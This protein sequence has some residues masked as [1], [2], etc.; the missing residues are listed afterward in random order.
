[1][2]VPFCMCV[3]V[4]AEIPEEGTGSPGTA[5]IDGYESSCGCWELN[6]GPLQEQLVLLNTELSLQPC[7][8]FFFKKLF[9]LFYYM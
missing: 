9:A 6:T 4:S 2:C 1:M 3:Y 5:I 7:F 8:I